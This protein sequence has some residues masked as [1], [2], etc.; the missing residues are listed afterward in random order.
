MLS[1]DVFVK[2]DQIERLTQNPMHALSG[3]SIDVK[4]KAETKISIFYN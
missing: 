3:R 1:N 4:Q 2:N